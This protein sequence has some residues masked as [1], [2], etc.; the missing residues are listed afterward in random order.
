MVLPI[1]FSKDGIK[2]YKIK[3]IP[4]RPDLEIGSLDYNDEELKLQIDR[5]I[6][7][8]ELN[9]RNYTAGNNNCPILNKPIYFCLDKK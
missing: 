6:K 4:P 1:L 5:M 2:D 8:A 3:L 7:R 9:K